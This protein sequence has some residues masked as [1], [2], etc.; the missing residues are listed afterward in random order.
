ML[1]SA[2]A[3]DERQDRQRFYR[4][5]APAKEAEVKSGGHG[6][7]QHRQREAHAQFVAFD[8]AD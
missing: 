3:I 1:G 7:E 8:L 4:W 5:P 6:R 2:F